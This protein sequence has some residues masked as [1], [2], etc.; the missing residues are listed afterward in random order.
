MK[1]FEQHR[2]ENRRLAT[3][4]LIAQYGGSANESILHTALISM[5]GFPQT[6]REEVRRDLEWMRERRLLSIEKLP[7]EGDRV[8][9]VVTISPDGLDAAAGRGAPV[10]GMARPA[11]AG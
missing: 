10:E 1:S 7:V 6:S 9:L 5:L 2:T 3:L 8:L 11:I 4:K